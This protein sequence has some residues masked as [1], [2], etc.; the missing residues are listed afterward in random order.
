M[1]TLTIA[2]QLICILF[3]ILLLA[4]CNDNNNPTAPEPEPTTGAVEVKTQTTGPDPDDFGDEYKRERN[5]QQLSRHQ[6]YRDH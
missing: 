2:K 1:K 5:Q 6:R 4:A 3:G